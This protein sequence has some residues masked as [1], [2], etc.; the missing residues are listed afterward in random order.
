MNICVYGSANE[1]IDISFRKAG[2]RLGKA[3][4]DAG[5]ALIFGGGASGMMGAVARG[6]RSGGGKIIGISPEFFNVD[7]TLFEDCTEMIYTVDMRSRKEKL[8]DMADAFIVT[9]GGIGTMDEF[10]ETMSLK[11]LR[12]IKKPLVIFNV[13]GF[14]DNLVSLLDNSTKLKFLGENDTKLFYVSDDENMIIEYLE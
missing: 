8:E 3:M 2:E 11:Q 10:F 9:P 12:I 7:G 5:H 1:E 6:V 13:N 4:A 14:Y